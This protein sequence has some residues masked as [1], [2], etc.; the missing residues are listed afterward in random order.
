[1]KQQQFL[2]SIIVTAV[3]AVGAGFFGGMK[4]QQSRRFVQF[5]NGDRTLMMRGGSGAIG[6]QGATRMNGFRPV[7]GE[8]IKADD[9]SIT[10]KLQDGSSKIVLVSEKTTINKAADGTKAD[11]KIGENVAVFGTETEGTV[12]AESIQ[13]NPMMRVSSNS[14]NPTP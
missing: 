14:A 12:K 11:L 8:I 6:M 7:A 3:V 4:Y 10:V 1:M 2:I 9:T 5:G 13:L